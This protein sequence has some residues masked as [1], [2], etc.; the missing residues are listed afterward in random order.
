[1]ILRIHFLDDGQNRA[2]S[3][4]YIR[5]PSR[6]CEGATI[7]GFLDDR[8]GGSG[9]QIL[10][11]TRQDVADFF[12]GGIFPMRATGVATQRDQIETG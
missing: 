9:K 4:N 8:I 3:V 7:H 10:G 5:G 1:M 11:I 12:L 2:I 6:T